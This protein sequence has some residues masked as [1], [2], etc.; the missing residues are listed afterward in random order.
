M[1]KVLSNKQ[2]RIVRAK[3]KG[4]TNRE[5]AKV[6]YPNAAPD[7]QDVIVSRELSKPAVKQYLEQTKL[8]ALKE[9]NITWSRIIAPISAALHATDRT[10]KPNHMIR[11]SAAKQARELLELKHSEELPPELANLP[12][13]VDE[14]QLVRLLKNK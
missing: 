2:K 3:I 6:E 13:D 14:I 10:G 8:Q 11:L 9:H 7:S 12:R 1:V 5:I 4:K